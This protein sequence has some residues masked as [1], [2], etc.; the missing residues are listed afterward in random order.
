VTPEPLSVALVAGAVGYLSMGAVTFR[1]ALHKS[2]QAWM[3]KRIRQR[4]EW[5]AGRPRSDKRVSRSPEDLLASV[6]EEWAKK[7]AE[8]AALDALISSV[9]W[10]VYWA[11]HYA[12]RNPPASREER[13]LMDQAAHQRLRE[14]ERQA[15][16]TPLDGED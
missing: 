11:G 9:V 10:P 12:F 6:R 1:A 8:D 16:L 3:D 15:G 2:R 13:A 4:R 5:E 7:G 14:L